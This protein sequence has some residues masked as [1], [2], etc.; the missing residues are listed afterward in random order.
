MRSLEGAPTV[1]GMWPV[2][3]KR[4]PSPLLAFGTSGPSGTGLSL[5]HSGGPC[6]LNPRGLPQQA[7]CRAG[8]QKQLWGFPAPRLGVPRPCFLVAVL[9]FA[10]TPGPAPPPAPRPVDGSFWA[11]S[12]RLLTRPLESGADRPQVGGGPKRKREGA[13]PILPPHT[14]LSPVPHGLSRGP[15]SHPYRS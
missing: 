8:R 4:W 15:G 9:A 1:P 14:P 13:G 12:W 2:P 10:R 6:P 11:G 3:L 5:S 7:A